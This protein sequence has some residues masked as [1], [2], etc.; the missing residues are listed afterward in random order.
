MP[1][2]ARPS[3]Y[4]YF[5]AFFL[6]LQFGIHVTLLTM[7]YFW[8]EVGSTVPAAQS[9]ARNGLTQTPAVALYTAGA[10]K[11]FGASPFTTRCAMLLLSAIALLGVFLLAIELC[12]S[13]QGAPALV[14]AALMALS[15]WFFGQSILAQSPVPA[16]LCMAYALWFLVTGRRILAGVGF[17]ALFWVVFSSQP[18]L[19]WGHLVP[20][21]PQDFVI[22]AG[23][24]AVSLFLANWHFL[25][26]A[27]VLLAWRSGRLHR[28]RWKL[29]GGASLLYFLTLCL[30]APA[31]DRDLLPVL[32]VFYTAAVAGFFSYASKWRMALPVAM[33]C[34]FV[35]SLWV[36]PPWW[37]DALENS[38]GMADFTDL[39]RQTAAYLEKNASTQTIATAW[40]LS[41]VLT[42]PALG[43]VSRPLPVARLRDFS[44]TCLQK[45]HRGDIDLMVRYSQG[46]DP[47]GNILPRNR[48]SRWFGRR[49]LG[50]QLSIEPEE[51]EQKLGLHLAAS[52]QV[53][54]HWVE[55]Y[56]R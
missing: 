54:G 46:W 40:P 22:L 47:P 29:A 27:G 9:A 15:P 44:A 42:Q 21:K 2:R 52:W 55:I 4:A 5:F 39:Q 26:T 6:I 23:R 3:T 13:L 56:G 41:A 38:L 36:A 19:G 45:I 50:Y 18:S 24:R 48:V 17:L 16:T 31:L 35:I 43:Y 34:G 25:A 33:L 8:D 7:P 14:V 30:A 32:P 11:L 20:A 49:Y 53:R 1:Q 51:I 10:W 28:T 37:P 12:G